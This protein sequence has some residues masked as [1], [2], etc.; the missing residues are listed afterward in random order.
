MKIKSKSVKGI[1]L[2]LLAVLI[3]V[4]MNYAITYYGGKGQFA[5]IQELKLFSIKISVGAGLGEGWIA[6][7][8][9]KYKI[10]PS[11]ITMRSTIALQ[12][13]LIIFIVMGI[14]FF[15]F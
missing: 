11:D 2:Y 1:L 9:L 13:I 7:W 15:L 4:I 8:G 12:G 3:F 5:T 6:Y 14:I 10:K